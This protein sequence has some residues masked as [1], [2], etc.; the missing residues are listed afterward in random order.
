[1]LLAVDALST[2]TYMHTALS[3]ALS[4][5]NHLFKIVMLIIFLRKE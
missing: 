2:Y 1:M 4:C 5:I 3:H